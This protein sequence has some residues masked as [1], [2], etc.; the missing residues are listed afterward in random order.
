MYLFWVLIINGLLVLVGFVIFVA[1]STGKISLSANAL[2]AWNAAL[3]VVTTVGIILT[4]V[5]NSIDLLNGGGGVLITACCVLALQFADNAVRSL[6]GGE[7]GGRVAKR[8]A[9][10]NP[11]LSSSNDTLAGVAISPS[12]ASGGDAM[13]G[14]GDFEGDTEWSNDPSST[15]RGSG[16]GGLF[17]AR[18]SS[19]ELDLIVATFKSNILSIGKENYT[20]VL[21]DILSRGINRM[22]A[23]ILQRMSTQLVG[24]ILPL[25]HANAVVAAIKRSSGNEGG[26]MFRIQDFRKWI[27]N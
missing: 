5:E 8:I 18:E 22:D 15:S 14:I 25:R 13:N 9:A 21:N 27:E 3:A 16:S 23:K 20:R 24:S 19:E 10:V 26:S 7:T 4:M 2:V 12:S 11:S 17:Q 6:K 1:R